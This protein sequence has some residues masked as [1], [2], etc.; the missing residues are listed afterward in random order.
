MMISWARS[1]RLK[2]T[3]MKMTKNDEA[4]MEEV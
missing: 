1:K 2:E 4:V 3:K